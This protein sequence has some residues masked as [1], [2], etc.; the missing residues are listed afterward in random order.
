LRKDPRRPV[1]G[2]RFD[3][4]FTLEVGGQRLVLDYRG[5]NHERGN[6]FILAP[7]QKVLMLVDVVYPGFM[8]YKNL[9]I[10]EDVQGWMEAHR[11]ALAYDFDVLVAGHVNKLGTRRDVEVSAELAEDLRKVS[12]GVLNEL[13]FPSFIRSRPAADKWD[14]HNEYEKT[15]VERCSARLLPRW[16]D[17]LADTATYLADNCS[18]MIEALTVT[19]P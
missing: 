10:A 9:G 18:T 19:L 13:D 8:P 4:S 15:L 7:R 5:V 12:A 11:Q 6:I 2:I 17:R 1:P 16:K 14:L 3:D